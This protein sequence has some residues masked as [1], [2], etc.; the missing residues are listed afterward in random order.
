[1]QTSVRVLASIAS[2]VTFASHQNSA[3]VLL[4]LELEQ[5][6]QTTLENLTVELTSEPGFLTPKTWQRCQAN[7]AQAR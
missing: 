2:K 6:G 1:M 7:P 4:D 3:P 5:T